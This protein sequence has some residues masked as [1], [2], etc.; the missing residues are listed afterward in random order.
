[1]TKKQKSEKMTETQKCSSCEGVLCGDEIESPRKDKDGSILCDEC[2]DE[3]YEHNCPICEE[4]FYEDLDAEITPKYLMV[5]E[6]VGDTVGLTAGIYEIISYPFFADGI[7]EMH[8][9]KDAVKRICDNPPDI[10]DCYTLYY[11]CDECAAKLIL[12]EEQTWAMRWI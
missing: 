1:M 2:Y 12:I 11:I 4:Y 10:E 8:I 9:F 7:I 3:K 6:K 5:L